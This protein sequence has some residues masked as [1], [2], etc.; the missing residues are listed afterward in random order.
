[1]KL[2]RTLNRKSLKNY[3]QWIQPTLS[4]TFWCHWR[5]A[6]D[7]NKLFAGKRFQGFIFLNGH[8]I[9]QNSDVANFRTIVKKI[10]GQQSGINYARTMEKLGQDYQAQHLNVLKLVKTS[11]NYL[12]KLFKTY[13]NLVGLWWFCIP[14]GQEIE[15]YIRKNWPE[16]DNDTLFELT[17]PA[18]IAVAYIICIRP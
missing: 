8:H 10:S 3:G 5:E 4:G 6:A 11:D 14:L 9:I 2:T 15:Q 12:P 13:K 7:L 17:K 1:M 18:S 16:I